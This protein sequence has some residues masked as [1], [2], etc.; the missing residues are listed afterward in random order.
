MIEHHS[1][2]SPHFEL[3]ENGKERYSKYLERKFSEKSTKLL[4]ATQNG[5]MVGFMLCLLSPNAPIFKE[6]TIGVVSDVYVCPEFR[7]RG[8]AKKML[9]VAI[10]WFHKNKVTSV[11]LSV[12]AANLEARSAWGQ[13]GFKPHM[14]M[15]RLDLDKYPATDMLSDETSVIRKKVVKRV[16]K[17]KKGK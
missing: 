5:E 1:R 13:L 6:K 17:D 10:R 3:S 8:V 7:K 2:L 9:K 4:V 16:R 11:Q 14:M 15:K 12:A